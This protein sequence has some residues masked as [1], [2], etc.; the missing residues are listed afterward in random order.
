MGLVHVHPV[1]AAG[2]DDADRRALIGHRAD[3]HGARMGAQHVGGR[4]SPSARAM[5]NVSCSC[6]AGCSG[7]MFS[8]SKLIPVA[9]DLR[10][11]GHG[12]AH[13]GEDRGNS[14]VTWLTGWIVP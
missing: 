12:K 4:L 5:K 13:V 7:G 10:A 14:S 9:F 1:D 6:R 11:F 3:L 8:A 2:G